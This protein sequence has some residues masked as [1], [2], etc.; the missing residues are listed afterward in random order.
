MSG[1]GDCFRFGFMGVVMNLTTALE[2]YTKALDAGH[3]DAQDDIDEIN[4]LLDEQRT[5]DNK[6]ERAGL[7]SP[8]ERG[9]KKISGRVPKYFIIRAERKKDQELWDTFSRFSITLPGISEKSLAEEADA[10]PALEVAEVQ[11]ASQPILRSTDVN[12][13]HDSSSSGQ[14]A[15]SRT[16]P[17]SSRSDFS[18]ARQDSGNSLAE[19][20]VLSDLGESVE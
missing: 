9:R 16:L 15:S 19:D 7:F 20:Q 3:E 1:L 17:T 12:P 8:T 10:E 11:H 6:Y 13:D 5:Y 14:A 2:W 18:E 4:A